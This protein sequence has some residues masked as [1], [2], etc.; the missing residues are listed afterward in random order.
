MG[1]EASRGGV[2]G[3]FLT[4]ANIALIAAPLA[5]GYLL[6]ESDVYA[7]VFLVAAASLVPFIALLLAY[8]LPEGN[9]PSLAD[10]R[11]TIHCVFGNRDL[12]AVTFAH[13]ILQCFYHLAPIFIPLYL[14]T[15]LGMPWSELGWMFAVML[16]P[17]VLIEYPA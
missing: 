13:F 7:R 15:A 1:G 12:A 8:R 16:V 11:T 6:G 2:G 9:P 14:H 3:A 17:Y 5:V 4:A 10:I